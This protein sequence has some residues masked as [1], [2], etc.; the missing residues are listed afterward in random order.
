MTARHTPLVRLTA[1]WVVWGTCLAGCHLAWAAAEG[2]RSPDSGYF[3]AV[4]TCID[5]LMR[6]GTD[7]YGQ[8]ISFFL[9]VYLLMGDDAHLK[10]A[11]DVADESVARLYHNGLFRGHPAKPYYE[12][13]DGVGQ[14][15]YAL[16]QLDR[17]LADPKQ[18]VARRAIPLSAGRNA[19]T[20]PAD[21]W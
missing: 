2:I 5:T 21:N 18:A 13:M 10:S 17:I 11:C 8:T 19:A 1:V 9:Q 3:S 7:R 4:Q 12:A 16:L 15:L 6:D 20:L 14:L